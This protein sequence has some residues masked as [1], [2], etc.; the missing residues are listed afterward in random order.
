[1]RVVNRVTLCVCRARGVCSNAGG[2]QNRTLFS[3]GVDDAAPST[4]AGYVCETKLTCLAGHSCLPSGMVCA[5]KRCYVVISRRCLRSLQCVCLLQSRCQWYVHLLDCRCCTGAV[6]ARHVRVRRRHLLFP[7][8]CWFVRLNNWPAE[9][10]VHGFVLLRVLLSSGIMEFDICEVPEGTVQFARSKHVL[11]PCSKCAVTVT[12]V[13][14][15]DAIDDST[16]GY[17]DCC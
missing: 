14:R 15:D 6:H 1:M 11:H 7:L 16:A 10:V 9:S 3:S 8:P 13:G 12:A 4:S 17:L 5:G 2:V